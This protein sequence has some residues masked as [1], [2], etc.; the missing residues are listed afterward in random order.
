[1]EEYHRD[2]LREL[3]RMQEAPPER[4]RGSGWITLL[5]LALF[6]IAGGFYLKTA[7][8]EWLE[9]YF[10]AA[11]VEQK[12]TE[13]KEEVAAVF[14]SDTDDVQETTAAG[15]NLPRKRPARPRTM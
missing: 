11:A 13:W 5:I 15:R 3:R 8:P 2:S 9:Q 10:D 1:M 6:L 14:K 7:R 4:V 12:M